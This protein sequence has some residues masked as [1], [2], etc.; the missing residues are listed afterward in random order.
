MEFHFLKVHLDLAKYHDLGR[1][2]TEDNDECDMS[3]AMFHLQQ[4]VECEV[5]E[6]IQ[7]MSKLYLDIGMDIFT[8][9]QIPVSTRLSQVYRNHK[10]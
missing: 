10:Q 8:N 2:K 7:I 6:A 4:A 1:F 5:L 3:A 9:L